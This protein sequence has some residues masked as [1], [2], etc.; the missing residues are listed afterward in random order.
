MRIF[1]CF[2][3]DNFSVYY[4]FSHSLKILSF[5]T[6]TFKIGWDILKILLWL[7]FGYSS[8]VIED[9]W[10]IFIGITMKKDVCTVTQHISF[11]GVKILLLINLVFKNKYRDT[12]LFLETDENS[13]NKWYTSLTLYLEI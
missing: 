4:A 1:D 12:I 6:A 10:D 8:Y 3:S 7:D 2:V 13:P 11:H 9:F 5:G